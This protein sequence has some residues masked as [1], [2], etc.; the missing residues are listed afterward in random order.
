LG[1]NRL[2]NLL[3][4]NAAVAALV[5]P[6]ETEHSCATNSAKL[7]NLSQK[8]KFFSRLAHDFD[9]GLRASCG[10]LD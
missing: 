7:E 5:I 8:A 6:A 9:P 3:P 4:V 1:L 10:D 2:P